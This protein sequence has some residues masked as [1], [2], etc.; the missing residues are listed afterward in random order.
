MVNLDIFVRLA[1]FGVFLFM[2]SKESSPASLKRTSDITCSGFTPLAFSPHFHVKRIKMIVYHDC[3]LLQ[4]SH[5]SISFELII[6]DAPAK[7]TQMR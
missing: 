5:P 3:N 7:S 4:I 6:A 2:A 1:F